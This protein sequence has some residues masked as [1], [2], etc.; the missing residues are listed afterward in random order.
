MKKIFMLIVVFNISSYYV[1]CQNYIR[2]DKVEVIPSSPDTND[3]V[4]I[5]TVVTSYDYG[6]KLYDSISVSGNQVNISMCISSSPFPAFRT[7][8]D[9]FDIGK[10]LAGNYSVNILL[11]KSSS[12]NNECIPIDSKRA[13]ITFDV[14]VPTSTKKKFTESKNSVLLYPNPSPA[15]QT[16]VVNIEKPQQLDI[17]LHDVAGRAVKYVYSGKAVP[18]EHHYT[19]NL[20]KLASGIYLLR[21]QAGEEILHVKTIKK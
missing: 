6:N 2:I 16:L 20:N 8:K 5:E 12:L 4:K 9:T 11:Y 7:F 18:G 15:H 1:F 19:I 17:T 21:V 10:L 3:V 13:E 14:I